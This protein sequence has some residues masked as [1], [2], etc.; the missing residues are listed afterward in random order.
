M[1]GAGIADAPGAGCAVCGGPMASA[2]QV[3]GKTIPGPYRLR[4]CGGCGFASVADPPDPA[5]VYTD[6]YYRGAGADPL[7]D[8]AFEASAPGRT[9]RRYEWRGIAARV[10]ALA[11]IGPATRWLDAGCGTGGLVAYLRGQVGCDAV[12][13]EEGWALERLRSTGIPVVDRDALPALRG[14]FDVVTAIEVIEHVSDPVPFLRGLRD[15]LRPGGLLFLTTGNAAPHRDDLAG[16][17]YVVPEIHVSFFEPRTLERALIAAGFRPAFP[18][19]GPGHADIIRFKVLKNVGVR[20]RSAWERA[21]PW[22]LI[23][24]A[25]DRRHG[26][27]AHPVGYAA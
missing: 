12:G 8:Y 17:S 19:F 3:R 21:L 9:I 11:P 22:P 16:W 15:L 4:R 7:V 1:A 18:G 26:V 20:T 24:R 6:D 5:R 27:S 10:G 23:A 25:V 13:Q 14:T 2:G